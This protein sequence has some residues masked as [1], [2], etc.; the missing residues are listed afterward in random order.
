MGGTP[1]L[2]RTASWPRI[3]TMM[4]RRLIPTVRARRTLGSES[5]ATRLFQAAKK[6]DR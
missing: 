4:A 1:E 5:L 3:P 6:T 2:A